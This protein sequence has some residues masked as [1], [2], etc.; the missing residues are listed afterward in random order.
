MLGLNDDYRVAFANTIRGVCQRN[1]RTKQ[2][3]CAFWPCVGSGFRS[4]PQERRL[5]VIGRAVNGWWDEQDNPPFFHCGNELDEN[6]LDQIVGFSSV[7]ERTEMAW[8]QE[9]EGNSDTA[10]SNGYNTNR[11]AF[12]RVIKRVTHD[13]RLAR[14]GRPWSESIAWSNLYKISPYAGGNPGRTLLDAQKKGCVELLR[15]EIEQLRPSMVL[16]ITGHEWFQE[17]D[18]CFG[19]S[20]SPALVRQTEWSMSVLNGA[21]VRVVVTER[22]ESRFEDAFVKEAVSLLQPPG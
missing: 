21:T 5:M 4:S 20:Y 22:P 2:Q 9:L 6:R 16:V 12:W 11:S 8:V 18:G 15:M 10:K 3:L 19:A 17:F 14:P 13:L 7:P 1:C